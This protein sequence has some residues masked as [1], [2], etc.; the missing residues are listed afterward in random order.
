M[1]FFYEFFCDFHVNAVNE[2]LY[3]FLQF[4]LQS[5]PR[6]WKMTDNSMSNF[7][8]TQSLVFTFEEH[9]IWTLETSVLTAERRTDDGHPS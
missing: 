7:E 4:F 2:L 5:K 8:L 6:E 1:R 9:N 3:N